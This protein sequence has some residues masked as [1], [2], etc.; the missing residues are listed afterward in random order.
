MQSF[1]TAGQSTNGAPIVVLAAGGIGS[2]RLLH[3]SG[4]APQA[5][6]FFSDPV[7]AVMG[8]VDDVDGGA[9]VAA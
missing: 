9:E 2:P 1:S 5:M 6:P 7:V 4:L 3:N 8:T